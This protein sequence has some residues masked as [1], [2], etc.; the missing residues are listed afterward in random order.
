M[1]NPGILYCI[2]TFTAVAL[3]GKEKKKGGGMIV[4]AL[5]FLTPLAISLEAGNTNVSSAL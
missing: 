5:R 4:L 3:T 2:Y 1:V